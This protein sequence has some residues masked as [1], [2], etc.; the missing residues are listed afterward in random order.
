MLLDMGGQILWALADLLERPSS[1]HSATSCHM[2]DKVLVMPS[3]GKRR[4]EDLE[5][6]KYF[7][8]QFPVRGHVVPQKPLAWGRSPL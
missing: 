6:K 1:L 4:V 3:Y 2:L 8:V 7:I 5:G